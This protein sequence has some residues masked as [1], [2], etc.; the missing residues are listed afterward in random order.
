MP[1]HTFPSG[2]T[3]SLRHGDLTAEAVDAIVNAAN[4]RLAHGG[5]VAAA[6]VRKGGRVIQDESDAWVRQHGPVPHDQPAITGAGAL[7]CQHVIHAVGPV[8]GAGD[9]DRALRAAVT[10]ALRLAHD[11]GLASLA[12]PPLSTGIFGFPKDRAAKI[13]FD[14][15]ATFCAQQP[16][17]PLRDI[18]LVVIDQPTLDV[19]RAEFERAF[20]GNA[21]LGT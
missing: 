12:L 15:V 14:A 6:I 19:F 3:V 20:T 17:S 9:E 21:R 11:R 18:R 1:E 5:G 2:Q 13:I 8:W 16:D 4:S 10:G 7:P